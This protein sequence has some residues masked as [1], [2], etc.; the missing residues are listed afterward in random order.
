MKFYK[1]VDAINYFNNLKNGGNFKLFQNDI[2]VSG[3]KEFIIT[4]P[5]IIFNYIVNECKSHYY[6]FWTSKCKILFSLDIDCLSDTID[7]VTLINNVIDGAK[8]YYDYTYNINDIIVLQ[9]DEFIQNIESP[10]KK[11]YHIIF[12]G[13]AFKSYI[14]CKDFYMRLLNDYDM[15]YCDK[16]IYNMTCLRLAFCSKMHKNAILLPIKIYIN[17]E[18]TLYLNN[19]KNN[20]DNLKN[21]WKLTLITY[22][23]GY[24]KVIEACVICI[25][26][27]SFINNKYDEDFNETYK[28]LENILFKLPFNYCDDFTCWTKIG[29]IL[30]NTS[31]INDIDLFDLWNRWSKQSTKY[32]AHE[33]IGRWNSFNKNVKVKLGIGTLIKWAKDENIIDVEKDIANTVNNYPPINIKLTLNIYPHIILNRNKLNVDC[34]VDYLNVD[35]LAVQSE[36]G[37][38]KTYNLLKALFESNNITNTNPNIKELNSTE[39][40]GIHFKD[41]I[42]PSS[43]STILFITSRRT[44]GF[45]LISDLKEWGFKLYSDINNHYICSRRIICQ[46]D[47]LLR[48]DLD[49]YDYVIVDECESVARYITS[50]HF[51]KNN[52]AGLIISS[53]ENKIYNAKY[54]YIMDADLSDRC[55][56]FYTSIKKD[57]KDLKVHIILNTYKAYS[58]YTVKYMTY[59][60]WLFN[61]FKHVEENKKLVVPMTSNNKAKNIY[62]KLTTKYPNLKV[63]IINKESSDDEK[64]NNLLNI[65]RDWS[66]YDIIIYTPSISMGVSY[67]CYDYFDYIYAYGCFNSLGSQEFCQ[68][69][70]RVRNPINKE[71]YLSIDNYKEYHIN[72]NIDFK[73]AEQILCS[74]YYL[75][76]Y[77]LHNNTIPK[78]MNKNK[79]QYPYKHESVY[80]LYVK[81]CQE[82][83]ED[84]LNF[85]AKFF[86]YL[87]YKEYKLEFVPDDPDNFDEIIH[88]LKE[89]HE[90]REKEE[91][92]ILVNGIMNAID[93]TEDD[94]RYKIKQ[95][96]NLYKYEIMRYNIV[97]CYNID[98]TD[99]KEILTKDFITKYK[100]KDIMKWFKNIS[101]I[102]D[103]P[104]QTTED[105]LEILK[106]NAIESKIYRDNCYL[107]FSTTDKY[108]YHYYAVTIIKMFNF[109]INDLNLTIDHNTMK[110]RIED[111]LNWCNTC[112]I[113]IV[114]TYDLINFI[115]T[116]LT[117]LDNSEEKINKRIKF[118]NRILR[119][120]YGLKIIKLSIGSKNYN[121]AI[122][123]LEDTL[124][125]LKNPRDNPIKLVVKNNEPVIY[126]KIDISLYDKCLS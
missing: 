43:D 1:K 77:D 119:F 103:H 17:N 98:P 31:I 71:I 117:K 59:S 106:T 85:C 48:L 4:K 55:I 100:I 38:G 109:D 73:T 56:N 70:H 3:A 15:K 45:K 122:S 6:E 92:E 35:V 118:I 25:Q 112:K 110:S 24:E 125:D 42:S 99:T 89:I 124:W 108:I 54:V 30:H 126:N 66:T 115:K 27:P 61:F 116:D 16:A 121:Y 11:S 91:E 82:Q 21:F 19:V 104:E 120:Q 41:N 101:T 53:L 96:N 50:Q 62:I 102:I 87:K 37:T 76:H 5:S 95:K 26:Q 29:M 105:K 12:R 23:Q 113:D 49:S 7:I 107:D 94:F 75:T 39:D 22:L 80:E 78:T 58:T 86:G 67:D 60:T 9:N 123:N 84:K 97:K 28:Y 69:L 111:I 65:N 90:R 10:N 57:C 88:E 8:K 2:D 74:D 81:N 33:M 64:L 47:S 44:F 34:F 32:K 114:K 14:V 52:R 63:L 93:L 36:K 46:L 51:I 79:I 13:L 72:D 18:S 20:V 83:I 40:L 68:M